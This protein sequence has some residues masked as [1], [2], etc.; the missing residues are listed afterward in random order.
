MRAAQILEHKKPLS[1][2]EVPDPTP[3]SHDVIV[4]VEACGICRS[5]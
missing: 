5:D 4:R 3:G 1:I 2:G